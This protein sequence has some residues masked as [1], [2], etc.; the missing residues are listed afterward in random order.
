[1]NLSVV[2]E[3]K[4]INKVINDNIG[5]KDYLGRGLLSQNILAQLRNFVEDII[6][7]DY[8]KKYQKNLSNSYNDKKM[9]YQDLENRCK[10]RF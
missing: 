6:V 8:N 4:N 1:M 3:I 10:P 5:N 7:L 2:N 9:A